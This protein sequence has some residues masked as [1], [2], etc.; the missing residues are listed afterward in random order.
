MYLSV[1]MIVLG[2]A[3]LTMSRGLFVYGGCW[4]VWVNIFVLAYEEPALR[5]Q[6]GASYDAYTRRV[7]RWIPTRPA[8]G[9]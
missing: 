5:H 1:T 3:L 2:E 8:S 4:F 7:G 6:F 9:L